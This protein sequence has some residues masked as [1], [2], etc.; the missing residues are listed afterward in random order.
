VLLAAPS[1][2][3]DDRSLDQRFAAVEARELVVEDIA[4]TVEDIDL[5]EA[6]DVIR[7]TTQPN[8]TVLDTDILFA[9]GEASLPSPAQAKLVSLASQIPDGSAVTVAGHTD[10]VGTDEANQALS[11][12]RAQAVADVLKG[13]KPSL[14]LTVTGF[15]EGK[16][17][18]DN[19]TPEH[20]NPEG[21]ALNRR[22]E[23]TTG[24]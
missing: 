17:I 18:S 16:P 21:R 5:P 14:V 12:A 23:I 4:L 20:D 11:L 8:V 7:P 2:L 22:V 9:F 19:G 6:R 3:A 24:T 1:A 10:S 13:A 15:G